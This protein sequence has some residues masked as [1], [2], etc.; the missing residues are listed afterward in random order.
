MLLVHG[1]PNYFLKLVLVLRICSFFSSARPINDYPKFG[2]ENQDK[3]FQGISMFNSSIIGWNG[4][5]ENGSTV[6]DIEGN[7]IF[8][9][10][11]SFK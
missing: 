5:T 11:N 8:K 7:L 6:G 3:F 4:H 1:V 10:T 9:P 2:Y